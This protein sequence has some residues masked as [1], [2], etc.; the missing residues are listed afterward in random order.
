MSAQATISSNQL[1]IYNSLSVTLSTL[2]KQLTVVNQKISQVN[3]ENRLISSNTVNVISV[4]VGKINTKLQESE[5]RRSRGRKR[6]QLPQ[7][8]CRKDSPRSTV[9][10]AAS[11]L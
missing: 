11:C 8:R 7:I 1:A 2:V 4:R 9:G 3:I 6:S 5:K 10:L